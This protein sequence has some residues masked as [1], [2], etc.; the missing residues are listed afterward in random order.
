MQTGYFFICDVLGF[1]NIVA[2]SDEDEIGGKVQ[3]WVDLSTEAAQRAGVDSVQLISDTLFASSDSSAEGLRRLIS[4]SQA[5]LTDGTARSLPVRGAIAHGQFQWSQLTYGK[6]VVGA[7]RLEV[8]QEWV[9]VTCDSEMPHVEAH[10][11][12]RSLVAYPAPLRAGMVRVYPVVAWDVPKFKDLARQLCSGGLTRKGE[13]LGWE[14][15]RKLSNTAQFGQYLRLL[16]RAKKPAHSSTASCRPKSPS[17]NCSDNRGS[18]SNTDWTRH[19]RPSP[20]ERKHRSVDTLGPAEP[21]PRAT[22][23]ATP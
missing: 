15:A 4:Y 1:S 21:V 9:G 2:N 22:T 19:T 11:D 23:P 13:I 8:A 16:D 14:W 7:H 12:I 17:W 18:R 10:W 20:R 3:A 5:L 6:A